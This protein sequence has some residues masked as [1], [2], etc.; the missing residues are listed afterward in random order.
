MEQAIQH[1]DSWSTKLPTASNRDD[2]YHDTNAA[3]NLEQHAL[4]HYEKSLAE[5]TR[6][7]DCAMHR[8]KARDYANQLVTLHKHK[9]S[10]SCSIALNLLGRIALD[11]G[12]YSLAFQHLEEATSLA[13]NSAGN[14]YSL[15]H[16]H[17]ADQC[18]DQA[19]E[20]FTKALD[21]SPNETRAAISIAYTLY[22]K[23][24]TVA[25]FQAYRKLFHVHPEDQHVQA[26]LFDLV[27]QIK[28][29]Y[30]QEELEQ[31]V[32]SWLMLDDVNSQKLAPLT[33]SLLTHKYDLKN[34]N[35]VLDLQDLAIDP[36]LSLALAKLYVTDKS[37]EEVII[38]IRKQLLLSAI[39]GDYQDSKL[40]DLTINIAQ[41]SQHNE[42]IYAYQTDELEI[43]NLLTDSL[44]KLSQTDLQSHSNVAYL[45][46]LYAMYESPTQISSL[47]KISFA[48]VYTWPDEVKTLFKTTV[49]DFKA[50]IAAADE[51]TTL[52]SISNEI[53]LAV[54]AQYEANPY[55]RWSHLGYNTPTN[56]GRALEQELE[57]F[58]A[59]EFFNMGAIKVLIAGCGTGQHALRVA[60]Y[61]RNVEVT[62]IDITRR[63]LAYAQKKAE[64]YGI[65]NITFMNLD[66][67]DLDALQGEFHVIECSGVLHHMQDPSVGL[68]KLKTKLAANGL[69]K[70]GLYSEVARKPIQQVRALLDQYQV[71]T[72]LESIRTLRQSIIE[73][74][75]PIDNKGILESQ[76]FYSASGCRDLLFHEQ[77]LLFS[78]LKIQQLISEHDLRF[79]G[80]VLPSDK[81]ADYSTRYP[82]DAKRI[83]LNNW[84]EFELQHPAMFSQMYQFYLQPC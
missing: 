18:Y 78:P 3:S 9:N 74:K 33:I 63:S 51:L 12:F 68:A 6:N 81:K 55:P 24:L 80:F 30:Y 66:I 38:I 49:L 82:D 28:A 19:L 70:L 8:Q 25:A 35:A 7:E 62:A 67:L 43:L 4:Y 21:I 11:E 29:D 56:Y 83:D 10:Q 42:Y 23:G 13:P 73:D 14:W 50:E 17:L 65:E 61:F 52:T 34:P 60:K 64:Q 79:L 40:L 47:L 27:H 44:K 26:K 71:P 41:H 84:Q 16:V 1:L 58:R 72:N 32:I 46:S 75:L 5:S 69:I 15:G 59:P 57:N 36:L 39:A 45:F 31:D 22:K 37:L 48:D 20:C 54:K 76:D 53:S 77:E 2:I